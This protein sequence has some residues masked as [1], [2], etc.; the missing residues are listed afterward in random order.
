MFIY[1][2]KCLKQNVPNFQQ[3]FLYFKQNVCNIEQ[4]VRNI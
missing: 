4:N 1:S 2:T 3:M